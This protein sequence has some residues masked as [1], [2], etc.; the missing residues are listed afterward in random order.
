MNPRNTNRYRSH[1]DMPG[2]SILAITRAKC[3]AEGDEKGPREI[4]ILL[5]TSDVAFAE[6]YAWC[7]QWNPYTRSFYALRTI[8]TTTGRTSGQLHRM[9][10][11]PDD[12]SMQ[13]DHI[14][15]VTTDTRRVNLRFATKPENMR[16]HGV[17]SDNTSG[18]SGVS[19]DKRDQCWRAY[20]GANG[21]QI[22]LG[23]FAIRE[24][25]EAARLAAEAKYHGAFA[26]SARHA[27]PM[28]AENAP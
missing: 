8:R 25:A 21:K 27:D 17:R 20:I 4:E 5:D 23:C 19:W 3:P 1:P 14:N 26:A 10:L 9:L 13:V 11:S 7:A 2:V 28:E 15:R 18:V 24:E 22:H 12:P 16:N 6:Q